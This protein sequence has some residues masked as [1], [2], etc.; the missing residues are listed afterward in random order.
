MD[1]ISTI[2]YWLITFLR[3]FNLLLLVRKVN[4]NSPENEDNERKVLADPFS[5][6]ENCVN[7]VSEGKSLIR[8]DS[9]GKES[10]SRSNR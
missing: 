4:H 3:I 7:E 2:T 1:Y 8:E 9:K 6:C 5:G 10:Y